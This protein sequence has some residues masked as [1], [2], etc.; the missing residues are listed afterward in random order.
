MQVTLK[1]AGGW[2]EAMVQSHTKGPL[3]TSISQDSVC[4]L[5]FHRQ[6]WKQHYL[7]TQFR[8]AK[9]EESFRGIKAPCFFHDITSAYSERQMP[10]PV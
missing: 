10:N 8:S 7:L 5:V 6:R 9:R 2:Q 3:C 4:K 1:G